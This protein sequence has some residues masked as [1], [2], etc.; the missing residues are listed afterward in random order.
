LT[1]A[2]AADDP[3]PPKAWL[4]VG[5]LWLV[6]ALNYLDRVMLIT[7]RTSIKSAIPMTEA[8]FGL[9]TSVFL[10]TYAVCSPFAGFIVD[11]V[12]RSRMIVISLLSWSVITGLSSYASS[13]STLMVLRGLMGIVESSYF[14]AAGALIMDYHRGPT[15]SLANGVHLSGVMVGTALGGLGGWM[16]ERHGW[17][18]AFQ[19]FGI[20][21]IAYALLLLLVLRDRPRATEVARV[22]PNPLKSPTPFGARPDALAPSEVERVAPNPLSLANALRNLFSRRAFVLAMFFWG[23]LGLASWGISGWMPS[24]LGE[25]FHLP[26]GKAG[27]LTTGCI[28]GASLLGMLAGGA[29]ADRWSRSNPQARRLV[30]VIGVLVA[31]PGVLLVANASVLALALTGLIIYGFVRPF[32]DANMMPILS[33]ITDRRYFATGIGILNGFATLV[34][35][36]TIYAGGALRDAHVNVF[37]LFNCGAAG[38]LV[39]AGLWWGATRRA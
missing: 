21:G 30:G 32:P 4:I 10:I 29:W 5:L 3:L 25:Q 16:A 28:G 8:Q 39:C 34:G 17:T 23:L 6:G 1:A 19:F 12:G 13:W 22:V 31:I 36:A 7:M 38:L 2:P 27:I 15:Q 26:Q 9:L 24:Y 18:F 33:Q 37:T 11:R 14:P 20:G 35:G